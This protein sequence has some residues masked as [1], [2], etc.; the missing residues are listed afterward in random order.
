MQNSF[1][2]K[3]INGRDKI[4]KHLK[5]AIALADQAELAQEQ[6]RVDDVIRQINI[7]IDH[8]KEALAA[9]HRETRAVEKNYS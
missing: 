8:T 9:A 1:L 6:K 5:G 7:Q 4:S 2:F 3:T